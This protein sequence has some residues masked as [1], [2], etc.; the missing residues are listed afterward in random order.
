MPANRLTSTRSAQ[1]ELEDR[2]MW[3]DRKRM[4]GLIDVK[5]GR[6]GL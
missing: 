5:K 6:D 2:Q 3:P 4:A 1:Q